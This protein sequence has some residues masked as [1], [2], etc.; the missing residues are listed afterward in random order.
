MEK[1]DGKTVETV[2]SNGIKF[3]DH[4]KNNWQWWIFATFYILTVI[5]LFEFLSR[6]IFR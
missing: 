6:K 2:T 5:V 3:V 1:I 4:F